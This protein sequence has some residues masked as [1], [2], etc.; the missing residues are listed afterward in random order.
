MPCQNCPVKSENYPV[1]SEIK[2]SIEKEAPGNIAA[3]RLLPKF[4]WKARLNFGKPCFEKFTV[5]WIVLMFSW[6]SVLNLK[7]SVQLKEQVV[8]VSPAEAIFFSILHG[9]SEFFPFRKE[10]AKVLRNIWPILNLFNFAKAT[11]PTLKKTKFIKRRCFNFSAKGCSQY[12]WYY[13]LPSTSQAI[14]LSNR[15]LRL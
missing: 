5:F 1:K 12:F 8:R 10:P 6:T 14:I 3:Q 2:G 9:I 15:Y 13:G 4:W 11:E 7:L